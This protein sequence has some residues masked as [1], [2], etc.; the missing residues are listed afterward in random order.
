M[1][2]PDPRIPVSTDYGPPLWTYDGTEATATVPPPSA[3]ALQAVHDTA[4]GI[5]ADPL[6]AYDRAAAFATLGA[7]D[8][9]ALLAHTPPPT[10]PSWVAMNR[11]HPLIWQRLAQIW[12][13]L[14]IL[15]HR[16]EQPWPTSARRALLLR[17]L[18]GCED[19]T[20]EAAAFALCVSAW[21]FPAQRAEV[22]DVITRR[23]LHAAKALG[24]RPT[25][26]HDPLAR[27]LLICPDIAPAIAAQAR[28][29]LDTQR[30]QTQAN[31][32]HLD[33]LK[34]LLLPLLRKW[35]RRKDK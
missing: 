29:A 4:A 26:L 11:E 17:L 30:Q 2:E 27:I 34:D 28:K 31:A 20:V 6:V 15:H 16:P 13:C 9:L 8:L 12:V 33:Q 21:R 1:L 10:A 35:G 19:W 22:A 18:L 32:A 7:E 5:W 25:Q 23:Y 24:R 14:G 3:E